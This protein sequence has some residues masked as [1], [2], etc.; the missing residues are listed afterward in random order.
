MGCALASDLQ[1][2]ALSERTFLQGHWLSIFLLLSVCSASLLS[3]S[4]ELHFL[5]NNY[6][7]SAKKSSIYLQRHYVN[8]AVKW[9]TGNQQRMGNHRKITQSFISLYL[10]YSYFSPDDSSYSSVVSG[11][12]TQVLLLHL[13]SVPVQVLLMIRNISQDP[14][15]SPVSLCKTQNPDL[16]IRSPWKRGGLHFCSPWG[17]NTS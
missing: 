6:G 12:P 10:I 5:W 8:Q 16:M 4:L 2:P 9:Q 15:G 7:I 3:I 14:P 17:S 1:N 13:L 11:I